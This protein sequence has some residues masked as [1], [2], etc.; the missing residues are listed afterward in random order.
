MVDHDHAFES[1]GDRRE[2]LRADDLCGQDFAAA[3]DFHGT[4]TDGSAQ[5]LAGRF[6]DRGRLLEH[7]PLR[8]GLSDDGAGQRMLGVKFETGGEPEHFLLREA[9][10]DELFGQLRL[11]VGERSG[12]VEDRG[13]AS[14][15]LLEDGGVFDNDGTPRRERNGADD[16]DRNGDEQRTRRGDDEHGQEAHRFAAEPPGHESNR[17]RDGCVDGAELI[18]EPAQMRTILLRLAHDF[19]DFRVAR[20]DRP[21]GGCDR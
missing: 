12:F 6:V 20:I 2:L 14:G 10:H 1:T 9:G 19:G 5:P 8:F 11:A 4:F 21:A 17:D 15:D 13:P 7:Q 18:A 3:G 16:R